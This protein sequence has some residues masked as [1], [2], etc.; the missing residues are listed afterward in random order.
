MTTF[1][2]ADLPECLQTRNAG[3]LQR[4]H[5]RRMALKVGKEPR[6]GIAIW[7]VGILNN[8]GTRPSDEKL[9]EVRRLLEAGKSARATMSM[10]GVGWLTVRNVKAEMV[11]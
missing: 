11:A 3:M 6:T 1:T 10:A 4:A 7:K 5:N 2:N 9:Q 8:N